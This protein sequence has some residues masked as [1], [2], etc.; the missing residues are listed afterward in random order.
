MLPTER[1]LKW[2]RGQGYLAGVVE[3]WMQWAQKK[4]GRGGNRVDLFGFADILA[5]RAGEPALA[6]QCFGATA[7]TLHEE[8]ILGDPKIS[9][10]VRIWLSGGHR[11]QFVCWR[12]LK[13]KRGGVAVIY[14]PR[15]GE[16]VVDQHTGELQVLEQE[17]EALHGS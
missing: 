7:W 12:K 3:R 15:V 17:A 11:L 6:L 10:N 14:R 2:V 13:R 9:E 8:K 16:V 1:T 4:E 5:V